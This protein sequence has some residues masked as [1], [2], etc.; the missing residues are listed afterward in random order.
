MLRRHHNFD[1]YLD[2]TIKRASTNITCPDLK[3]E[4]TFCLAC[5]PITD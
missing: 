4:G 1:H 3:A 2:S 5:H